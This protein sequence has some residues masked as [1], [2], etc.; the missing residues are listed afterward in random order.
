VPGAP[1]LLCHMAQYTAPMA[2]AT[3]WNGTSAPSLG[4]PFR[5]CRNPQPKA[6]GHGMNE[7]QRLVLDY[8]SEAGELVIR[9]LYRSQGGAG[10]STKARARE[11]T[12]LIRTGLQ[13][14]LEPLEAGAEC[15]GT[16]GFD[17]PQGR[18]F[19]WLQPHRTK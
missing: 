1:R 11:G 9:C 19:F 8:R 12:A 10:P 3:A 17:S 5:W 14:A 4:A 2:H 7:L 13:D 16:S 15:V 18:M 6:P